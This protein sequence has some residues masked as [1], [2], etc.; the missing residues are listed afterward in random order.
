MGPDSYDTSLDLRVDY[1]SYS[2]GCQIAKAFVVYLVGF[3][4]MGKID[5]PLR[6]FGTERSF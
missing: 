6:E 4:L 1:E 5:L 3:T 2:P